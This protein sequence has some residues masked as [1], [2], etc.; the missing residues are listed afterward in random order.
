MFAH[1][2]QLKFHKALRLSEV[3]ITGQ[4]IENFHRFVMNILL[5]RNVAKMS[6][7]EPPIDKQFMEYY[8]PQL[9]AIKV[10]TFL[11]LISLFMLIAIMVLVVFGF[12][13]FENLVFLLLF[14]YIL[15]KQCA[16]YSHQKCILF[17][18]R[19]LMEPAFS[20]AHDKNEMEK[21]EAGD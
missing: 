11:I 8:K 20:E 12:L 10:A 21:E 3:K 15:R 17:I 5:I 14:W 13:T 1:N 6:A 18:K 19:Y 4:S 7:M 9:K 16:E 2:I